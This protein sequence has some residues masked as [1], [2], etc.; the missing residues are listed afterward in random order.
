MEEV[1]SWTSIVRGTAN[2]PSEVIGKQI[3][4]QIREEKE[5]NKRAANLIIKGLREYGEQETTKELVKDFLKDQF[6]W[7]G[8]VM[9]T[10]RI[11]RWTKG[12]KDRHV[13]VT[14]KN[15]EDKNHIMRKKRSLKGTHIYLDDDLTI[16]QQ[17]VRRKEWEKV[18]TTREKWKMGM[19]AKREGP[20]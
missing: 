15:A 12:C 4:S 10:Q 20:F 17:E 5:I 3:R 14:M 18:K 7:N 9:Q 2:M 1:K 19:A 13:T 8:V 11:G 6:E 16:T